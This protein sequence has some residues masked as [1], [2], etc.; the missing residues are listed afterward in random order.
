MDKVSKNTRYIIG[1]DEVGRGPLAGPV[2]VC[3]FLVKDEKFIETCISCTSPTCAE[4]YFYKEILVD[5]GQSIVVYDGDICL[6][7]GIVE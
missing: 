5:S 2:A 1:I 6:G 4:I 3:A 7:G